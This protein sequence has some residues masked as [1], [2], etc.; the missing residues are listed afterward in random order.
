MK[1]LK[2]FP[3]FQILFVIFKHVQEWSLFFLALCPLVFWSPRLSLSYSASLFPS[4]LLSLL[5]G[6]GTS[7]K[8]TL[9]S[10]DSLALFLSDTPLQKPLY[11]EL[12]GRLNQTAAQHSGNDI[13]F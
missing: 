1:K 2:H 11:S 4:V 8:L 3:C 13:A 10:R 9:T 5:L 7:R 6:L 12:R